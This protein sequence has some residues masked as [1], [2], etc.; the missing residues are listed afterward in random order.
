MD[1]PAYV[2]AAVRA[3]IT[4]LIKGDSWVSQG[5]AASLATA[6]EELSRIDQ[7]IETSLHRGEDDR[8][9]S[10]RIEKADAL[11]HRNGLA[12]AVDCLYRLAHDSRMADAFAVLTREFIDDQQWRDFIHAAWAAQMNF[13]PYRERLTRA[14][15]LKGEIAGAAARLARLLRQF[16][17]TGINGPS[18]FFSIPELLRHTDHYEEQGRNLY[19]WRTI[20]HHVLGDLPDREIPEAKPDGADAKPPTP[21]EIVIEFMAPGER[22]EI[23]PLVQ[24][25]DT[26]R[27]AWGTAPDFPALLD[28][29]ADAAKN[30]QP[31]DYGMIGAALQSRQRSL[32][33]EY[34]RA[35]GHLLTDAHGLALT[36]PIIQAMA[37]TA[38][39]VINS[40]D[41]DVT[42]D[43]ARKTLAKPDGKRLE[44]SDE[45]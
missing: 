9:S 31:S 6:E 41:V 10:L 20:R 8:L 28:T 14:K 19:M 27:Y 24:A 39:V 23:D 44:N 34:L 38:N 42:Y 11:A 18:E 37:I 12:S 17:E 5:W 25:R 21:D 26:L 29:V 7:D 36:T 43:D 3:H 1:F 35:F 16:A 22:V 4:T 2:P 30:F 40:P 13:K 15:E 32:K 45:K 33:A